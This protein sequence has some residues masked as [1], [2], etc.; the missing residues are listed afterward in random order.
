ML[1]ELALYSFV[2]LLITGTFLTFF[3]HPSETE[4]VYNGSYV[5]LKGL[6]ASEAYVSVINISFDVRAGLLVRQIH[7]WAALLF[8]ASIVIHMCR[9]FFTGAFRKPRE[10]NWVIGV[11]LLLLAMM[12][13]FCGYSLPDDLLSGTGVRIGYSIIESIP[14]VGSYIAT[15]FFQGQYPGLGAFIPRL[16]VL[17]ILLIPGLLL[18]LITAHLMIVWHQKHTDFPQ[19][20]RTEKNVIGSR[21]WPDY[22]FK[23]QGLFFFVFGVLGL[24][25]ALAQINPIW[26]WGP[27][28]PAQASIGS[29]PD[30]YLT[31]LEGS[32]RLMT[33]A[34]TYFLG[35]TVVW[36]VFLPAV[37]L[38]TLIFLGF[39]LYPFIERMVTNDHEDHELLERP[40]DN[41]TRTA[42]GMAVVVFYVVLLVAGSNDVAAFTFKFN[43]MSLTW[44][45]RA[46]VVLLPPITFVLTRRVCMRLQRQEARPAHH[47]APRRHVISSTRSP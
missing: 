39:Y 38:P 26:L 11:T 21:I 13:G 9:I 24:L 41:P 43:L 2:I 44:A 15:F 19:V 27:Y 37:V 36:D 34:E 35:H 45:L 7:H 23:S 10:L 22:T 1:G 17:H 32:L 30:W 25:G 20:A 5:P 14:I 33:G 18:A 28:D 8:V 40:R 42:I 4:T 6:H 29:Q 47:D 16:Y 31:W 3:F 12:E 46:V